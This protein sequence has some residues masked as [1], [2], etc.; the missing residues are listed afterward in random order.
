[1]VVVPTDFDCLRDMYYAYETHCKRF[2]DFS[3]KF[4]KHLVHTCETESQKQIAA[5]KERLIT[6][7]N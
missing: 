7:C 5:A 1:M 4:V 3:L 2:E 6:L